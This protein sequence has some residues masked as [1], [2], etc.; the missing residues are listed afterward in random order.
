[1]K[2][3]L[4][5]RSDLISAEAGSETVLLRESTGRFYGLGQTGAAI[6]ARLDTP[7]STE[8]LVASVV[9]EFGVTEETAA[10]DLCLFLEA[11]RREDL[12]E[13]AGA[14]SF[15]IE[16]QLNDSGVKGRARCYE[17]PRLDGGTLSR[18]A[19]DAKGLW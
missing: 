14:G 2:E 16:P 3:R 5:K 18:A 9:E 6:W 11:L 7:C 1:M 12:V 13:F 17:P 8:D 15:G 4:Q 10:A 19:S